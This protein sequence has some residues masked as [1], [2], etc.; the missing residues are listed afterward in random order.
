MTLARRALPLVVALVAVAAFLPALDAG[1]V[2][3]DD[4]RNFLENPSY[5]GLGWAELR[6]MFTATV[7]PA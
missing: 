3:W 7:A 6:W 1:F 4:D 5:R 2:D